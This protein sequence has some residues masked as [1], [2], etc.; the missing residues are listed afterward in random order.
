MGTTLKFRS[1]GSSPNN[2]QTNTSSSPSRPTKIDTST[3]EVCNLPFIIFN[4]VPSFTI[5]LRVALSSTRSFNL[6]II[7][8]ISFILLTLKRML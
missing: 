2:R 4:L 7:S 3:L 1:H 5:D 6:M 8:F